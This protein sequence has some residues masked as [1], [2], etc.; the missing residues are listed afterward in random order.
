[1]P[2][3]HPLHDV[4]EMVKAVL[5]DVSRIFSRIY[6]KGGQL[7]IPPEHLLRALFLQVLDSVRS[8]WM[9]MEQLNHNLLFRWFVG[10]N[11][12]DPVRSLTTSSKNPERL[13]A[14]AIAEKFFE[15]V[16]DPFAKPASC[17]TNTSR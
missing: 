7:L 16:L 10:L 6:A 12:D 2:A 1:M 8:E 15:R 5:K 14:A 9:L 3:D 11:V 17:L 4:R 13:I